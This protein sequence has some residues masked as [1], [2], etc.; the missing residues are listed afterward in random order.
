MQHLIKTPGGRLVQI[1][2]DIAKTGVYLQ[3]L[4]KIG[5]N[6]VAVFYQLTKMGLK[7]NP[8]FNDV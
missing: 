3:L 5:V 2:P 4:R 1:D 8:Q 6:Q 7:E